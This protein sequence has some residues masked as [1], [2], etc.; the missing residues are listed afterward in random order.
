MS[1]TGR[2]RDPKSA[3]RTYLDRV[4][5]NL[6]DQYTFIDEKLLAKVLP[7][8]TK[9]NISRNRQW[10]P[11]L[12]LILPTEIT[13][14]WS[15]IGMAFDYRLR[16]LFKGTDIN[17]LAAWRGANELA[18]LPGANGFSHSLDTMHALLDLVENPNTSE[19]NLSRAC[20]VMARL[21]EIARTG[22]T[23]ISPPEVIN[24]LHYNVFSSLEDILSLCGQVESDDITALVELVKTNQP[25][26]IKSRLF[27]P[28]P[29]FVGSY[30]IDGADADFI[31]DGML[32]DIKTSIK[33]DFPK[34]HLLQII[35]YSLLDWDDVFNIESVG[36]Y[37]S[38]QGVLISWPLEQLIRGATGQ[39]MTLEALRKE[40]RELVLSQVT[41]ETVSYSV[42]SFSLSRVDNHLL[43]EFTS[44]PNNLT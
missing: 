38:R 14:P 32:V 39:L 17:Q 40:F 23:D 41:E 34:A 27:I 29:T 1:L 3:E 44:D 10:K 43:N 16:F 24:T 18:N 22:R 9:I 19:R 37:F 36:V 6:K 8:N 21:E 7:L 5:Y 2:L 25:Q 28:N 13:Y 35:G 31:A 30:A 42:V 26:L 15:T 20:Y 4:L 12:P 33:N 11:G